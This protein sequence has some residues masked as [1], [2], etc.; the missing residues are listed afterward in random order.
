MS[1]VEFKKWQCSMSL[2]LI[3]TNVT[4]RIYYI[5]LLIFD[6]LIFAV[7]GAFGVQVPLCMS[8]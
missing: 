6:F 5:V 7:Y 1:P 3:Y 2:S 4:C 8:S